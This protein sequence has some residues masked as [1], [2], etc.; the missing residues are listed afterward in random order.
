MWATCSVVLNRVWT[1]RL[2]QN[3]R[4]SGTYGVLRLEDTM[5]YTLLE[6]GMYV[7]YQ[8]VANAGVP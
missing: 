5:L 2:K 3:A 8:C 1:K 7:S 4:V 6:K